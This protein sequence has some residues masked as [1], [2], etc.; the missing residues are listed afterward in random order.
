MLMDSALL[1]IP[2]LE[3]A[4][5]RK[6][7]NGPESFTPDNQFLLG[8]APGLA[9]YF[10]GAGFNS[11]GIAS[12]GGAGRALAEW[13]V[14]GRA[15]APTCRPSTSAGSRRT[16]PTRRGCAAGSPRSSACTTRCPGPTGSPRPLVT[17]GCRRCTTGWPPP[18]PASAPATAGS[19][20]S[21]SPARGSGRPS[22]TDGDKPAWLEHSAAEQ[23]ACRVGRG[24]LRPDVVLQVRRQRTRRARLPPV[25]LRQ[26]RR[27]AG[28]TRR[29]HAVAER[30]RHLRVRCHRHPHRSRTGSWSCRV[31]P[32]RSATWPGSRSTSPPEPR[33]RSPTGPTSSPS[34]ALMGPRSRDLLGRLTPAPL[35]DDAFPFATSQELD[36]AGA[37]VRATRMTYVGELGL[38]A[39][40]APRR[41]RGGLRRAARARRRPRA[42]ERRLLGDRVA[43]A[44]EGLP[45]LRARA[46]AGLHAG[47]GGAGLRDGAQGR[48]RTSSAARPWPPTGSGC[49]PADRAGGWCRSS[50]ATPT[51]CSGAA[52][53]VLLDGDPSAR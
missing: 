26:R 49:R 43:A 48:A 51:R 47:R 42:E 34:W 16:P 40:G 8:E 19:G 30:P 27:R 31:P 2:A 41:S 46:D 25:G 21:S 4:G 37:T 33:S 1:R 20:R 15:D 22:T 7:Y 53:C 38:G 14:D 5:I 44:G 23:R 50:S 17:S 52:S 13:I 18:G 39:A 10:V 12:A 29:L 9:G 24:A 32:P 36:V 45:G 6:F 3:Q 35:D 11:V 28:G